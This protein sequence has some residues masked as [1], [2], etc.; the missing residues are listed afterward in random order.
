MHSFFDSFFDS[1]LDFLFP[2]NCPCCRRILS[3]SRMLV[4]ERCYPDLPWLSEEDVLQQGEGKSHCV[5][6]SW[7]S[8]NLREIIH[9]YKFEG[10]RQLAAPLAGPLAQQINRHYGDAF[11]LITWVPISTKT[12][13][14]R[15]YDQSRLLA[16]ALAKELGKSTFPLLQKSRHTPAQSSLSS[17]AERRSNVMGAFALIEPAAIVGQRVLIVDDVIT[18][19]ATLAEVGGILHRAGAAKVLCATLCRTPAAAK[20]PL[21]TK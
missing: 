16:E 20:S 6:A 3:H 12:L 7:F 17:P 8:G 14:A 5:S 19:G 1:V 21:K 9:A 2:S 18:T 4:C 10:Y 15:G 11:D 13:K